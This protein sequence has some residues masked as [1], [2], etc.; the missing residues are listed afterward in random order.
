MD[1]HL[2]VNSAAQ[3][4]DL[5]AAVAGVGINLVPKSVLDIYPQRDNLA[6]RAIFEKLARFQTALVMPRGR[7]LPA[8]TALSNTLRMPRTVRQTA[9]QNAER[10][11]KKQTKKARNDKEASQFS[12][13]A[14]V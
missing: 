10:S 4:R 12:L 14:Q 13:V 3:S 11:P 6:V 7:H 2:R 8:L 1:S 9:T 5:A